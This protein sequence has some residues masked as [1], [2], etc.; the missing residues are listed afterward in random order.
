MKPL[1][2]LEGWQLLML[3]NRPLSLLG[4]ATDHPKF[5][6]FR[7]YVRTSHVLRFDPS[8][9]EAET[10]N[11]IYRLRLP[12]EDLTFHE[13][14]TVARIAIAGLVADR[15]QGSWRWLI[16]HGPEPIAEFAAISPREVIFQL[17]LLT[18]RDA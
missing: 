6:G 10:V 13:D 12:V 1:V 9:G 16:L 5:S 2:L 8:A 14:G 7:H 18:T 15:I 17:L 4:F 11:T 3:H